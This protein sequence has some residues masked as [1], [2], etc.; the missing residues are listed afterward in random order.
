MTTS[1]K[2]DKLTWIINGFTAVNEVSIDVK[3]GEIYGFLGSNGAGKTSTIRML[4]GITRPTSGKAEVLGMDI[5]TEVQDIKQS[6]GYMSQKFS[7]YDDLSVAENL[8]FFASVY[9][10]GSQ[11]KDRITE[12][13]EQTGLGGR[14]G[15]ITGSLPFGIKQRLALASALLHR[16]RILFLDE[17][18]AGVDPAG[19]RSFWRIINEL[20][21]SGVTV[22]VT[23]HYMDEAEYCNRVALMHAGKVLAV[24]TPERLK[25]EELGGRIIEID[26]QDPGAALGA[27]RQSGFSE[28]SM[29]ANSLH[30]NVTGKE[31]AVSA[32]R[33]SLEEKGIGIERIEEVPPS[34]EDVFL[35][36]IG[37][38]EASQ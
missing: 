2:T 21:D 26:C 35:N 10:V 8:T 6:I 38:E 9:G 27:L 22:F 19:R 12:A 15:L 1:V 11:A 28:V 14:S 18:T 30:V 13:L 37:R 24:G 29:F 25:E 7:L 3:E 31:E 17:P 5:Y 20:S 4:C 23:T 32:I 36:V 16:P 33:A 34:L